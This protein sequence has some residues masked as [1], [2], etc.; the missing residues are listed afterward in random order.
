MA[1]PN[2][3]L[4]LGAFE[5]WQA[6]LR[7]LAETETQVKIAQA[8]A[9]RDQAFATLEKYKVGV[10]RILQSVGMSSALADA[11]LLELEGDVVLLNTDSRYV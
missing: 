4:V 9:Q 5:R 6:A 1:E 2:E 7:S 8:E 11:L 10:R 3:E